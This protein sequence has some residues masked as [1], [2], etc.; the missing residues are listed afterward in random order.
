MID[1]NWFVDLD[2]IFY[3]RFTQSLLHFFW[4]GFVVGGR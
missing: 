3:L 2:Q 1:T 4:Q